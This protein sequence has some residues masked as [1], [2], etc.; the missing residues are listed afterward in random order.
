MAGV[1]SHLTEI[2]AGFEGIGLDQLR[3]DSLMQRVDRKFAVPATRVAD[4]LSAC[5]DD[6]RMLE[7]G[8]SRLRRYLTRYFDTPEL[9]LYHAHHAGRLPRSKVR[10]REYLDSG[11]RYLE[12]KRRS[13]TAQTSKWRV[14]LRRDDDRPLDSHALLPRIVPDDVIANLTEVLSV[15]YVRMTLVHASEAERI[16]VDV[17]LE[18]STGYR[19][20]RYSGMAL[21][22]VKQAHRGGTPSVARL[23]ACRGR[24]S[25][26]SKYCLGVV[27]LIEG[28]KTNR[29]KHSVVQLARLGSDDGSA[30]HA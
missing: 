21:V 18:V 1:R 28:A 29:F 3:Q 30:Q 17:G 19:A 27:T 7:V 25:S 22:E 10:I 26:I 14:L 23:R 8:G 4:I 2:A 20:V 9:A 16:T 12:V 15:A 13:N 6:Y 11:D 24:E 5:H